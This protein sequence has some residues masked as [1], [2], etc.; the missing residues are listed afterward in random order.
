[1]YD[2]PYIKI[3]PLLTDY[4]SVIRLNEIIRLTQQDYGDKNYY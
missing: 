4:S 2:V 1:M 3:G